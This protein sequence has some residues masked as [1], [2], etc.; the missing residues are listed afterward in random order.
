MLN[1]LDEKQLQGTDRM[2]AWILILFGYLI[3]LGMASDPQGW[4]DPVFTIMR[5]VPYTPYSWAGAFA[6]C[7]TFY[8]VGELA[9][10]DR[11]WR[12]RMIIF[13]ALLCAT[14]CMAMALCMSRMVYVM[15]TRITDLWPLVMAGFSV[16]YMARIVAYSNAF[17]GA[18]WTSNPYQLWGTTLL[19][20]ASISQIVIGVSPSSV[21]TEIGHPVALQL[22]IGNFIGCII[23]MFGLHLKDEDLAMNLEVSGAFSLVVT[24][25]WY[26]W[27]VLHHQP[28]ASTTLGLAM[29]EAFLF[30][31]FHRCLQIVTLRWAARTGRTELEERLKIRMNPESLVPATEAE[32]EARE[33]DGPKHREVN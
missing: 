12:G 30:A 3:A 2:H 6:L 22:A 27:T 24:V 21:F 28:L 18:R 7:T 32:L 10:H 33:A 11:R 19:M 8:A 5:K 25:G 15:P 20:T 14:W 16:L 23:I 26:C 9:K 1:F 29:P 4:D 31:T 17:T 13:G